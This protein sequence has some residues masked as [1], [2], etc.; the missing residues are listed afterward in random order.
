M[1]ISIFEKILT[2]EIPADIVYEDE[3]VL[4]FNDLHPI[5]P[6]HVLVIPKTKI[7]SLTE[8]ATKDP[9]TLGYFLMGVSKTATTLGL[10]QKG[11]RVVFNNGEDAQQTVLYLHAH[12]LA[13]RQFTWPPG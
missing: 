6:T 4:S 3:Y 12:I 11:Y 8:I 2:Q 1:S 5:A 10:N 9:L 13:G 7:I